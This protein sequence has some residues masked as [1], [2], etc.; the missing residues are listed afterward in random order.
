MALSEGARAGTRTRLSSAG[1]PARHGF[2]ARAGLAAPRWREAEML[3]LA[4]AGLCRTLLLICVAGTKSALAPVTS[5]ISKKRSWSEAVK[6]ASA[7]CSSRAAAR[8]EGEWA[9]LAGPPR[10]AGVVDR[11]DH[12]DDRSGAPPSPSPPFLQRQA[13]DVWMITITIMTKAEEKLAPCIFMP[14]STEGKSG[15][16]D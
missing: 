16:W 5:K 10:G 9:H 8:A 14:R 4:S 3:T 11:D 6:T 13:P 15:G 7:C 2:C 12:P 1:P